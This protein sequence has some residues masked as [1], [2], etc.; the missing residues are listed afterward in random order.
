LGNKRINIKYIL[1]LP[2]DAMAVGQ[3]GETLDAS[4]PT[5]TPEPF[6]NYLIRQSPVGELTAEFFKCF[7]LPPTTRYD[8]PEVNI[9][10]NY[11]LSKRYTDGSLTVS[12]SLGDGFIFSSIRVYYTSP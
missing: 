8:L 5:G 3:I 7:T 10:H 2:A 6:V 1:G 12:G 4:I 9:V 11:H